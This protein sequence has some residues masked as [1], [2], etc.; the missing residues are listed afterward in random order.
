MRNRK[1]KGT[2][3]LAILMTILAALC[4]PLPHWG[5]IETVFTRLPDQT[6]ILDPGHGGEDGGAVSGTGQSE[7]GVNLAIARDAD[8]LMGFFGV[9]TA[10]TRYGDV[11]IH[12]SGAKTLREKKRS[13]LKNRAALINGT[14]NPT[15]ISIHQNASPNPKYH[16]AQV[17]YGDP[18][19]SRP[20]ASAI[21][22]GI[23]T[24]LDP[25]NQREPQRVP[26]SIYLMNHISCRAVLV[27]CGFLSNPEEE[28]RLLDDT[29]QK[30]LAMVL[31]AGYL[32][33]G[34]T[35]EGES[36]I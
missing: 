32:T 29:Y 25:E 31:T 8:C 18:V 15:L 35:Q 12:D 17:F 7:S 27:E 16:G 10:L 23:R 3:V 6:L 1:R 26:D 22:E 9:R 21:Q 13:D 33:Q 28:A 34:G 19:L 2:G 24:C 30:K 11:S 14:S 4:L 5:E 36:L 20:L